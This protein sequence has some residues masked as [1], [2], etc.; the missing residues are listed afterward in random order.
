MQKQ[1]KKA[2]YLWKASGKAGISGKR[3]S[4]LHCQPLSEVWEGVDPGLT[5]SSHSGALLAPELPW[6]GP[7]FP[8]GAQSLLQAM[9]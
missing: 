1:R 9:T 2:A 4:Y 6:D 8:P 7:A 3:C 5:P